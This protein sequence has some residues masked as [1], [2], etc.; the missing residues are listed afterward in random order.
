MTNDATTNEVIAYGRNSYGTLHSPH[1]F[2]TGGRGSGGKGDPLGS[3]GSLT[4]SQDHHWLFAV[5]AGSGT[6]SVFRVEDSVLILTDEVPT[7]GAEPTA[8]TQHGNLVYV[9]NAAGSSSVV[10][11]EFFEGHLTPIPGSQQFLSANGANPGAVAFSV[12]GKFLLATEKTICR[13]GYG[14]RRLDLRQIRTDRR[15]IAA[16]PGGDHLGISVAMSKSR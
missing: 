9:L 6:L 14:L 5:N 11:F 13:R 2:K 15:K 10:G 3:Q 4:L 1:T 7:G 8:V 16:R 12:D